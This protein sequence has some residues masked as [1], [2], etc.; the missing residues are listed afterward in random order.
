MP[1]ASATSPAETP[2]VPVQLHFGKLDTHIPAEQ[3]ERFAP[4]IRRW[5]FIGMKARDTDSIATCAPATTPNA[6]AL[7]RS[8]ALAFLKKHL[9]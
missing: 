1:G 2:K 8:R 9:T 7:A 5:R 4:R 3:V 6:S